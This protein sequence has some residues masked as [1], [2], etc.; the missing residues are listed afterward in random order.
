MGAITQGDLAT[1]HSTKNGIGKNPRRGGGCVVITTPWSWERGVPSIV[2]FF[3]SEILAQ[4]YFSLFFSCLLLES[5]I[6]SSDCFYLFKSSFTSTRW[7]WKV[8]CRFFQTPCTILF[9]WLYF[10]GLEKKVKIMRYRGLTRKLVKRVR[11]K[12][13]INSVTF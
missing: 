6:Q 7:P 12:N 4:N 5:K 8:T 13:N 10:L 11:Y 2:L 3:V 9:A 1:F